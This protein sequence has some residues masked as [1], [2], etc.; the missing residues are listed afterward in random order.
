MAAKRKQMT[1]REKQRR[2]AVKKELQEKGILPPDKPRLNRRRY[3]EQASLE[4]NARNSA[5]YTWDLY[6][7]EAITIML[8]HTDRNMRTSPE[9]VGVAKC[10][11]L[12]IR[13]EQFSRMLKA[14]N[15]ETY[16]LRKQLDYIKDILDA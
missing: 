5:C 9:A 1:N 6:L 2:A 3:V 13:L 7:Y 15:R 11:K 16:T 14:E 4:W 8:G 12:A 10:L